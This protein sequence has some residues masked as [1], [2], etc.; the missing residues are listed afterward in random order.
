MAVPAIATHGLTKSFGGV[1]VLRG[2]EFTLAAGEALALFGPNGAGKSTLLRL[3]AALLRPT[4][5]SVKIFGIDGGDGKP[6]VRRR[7]GFLSHQ[8]FLYPD[9][10]PIEN[11]SFY[12]RMFRVADVEKR[13]RDLIEQVG[14]IGWANR[15]VRTLSRGLEQRCALARALLHDPDLLLLD[16]PFTGLDVDASAT[17]RAVLDA[18]HQRGTA[19]VM[20]THDVA[21]GL[22]SCGRA[23]ILARGHLVWDG[24]V[25]ATRRDEF[26]R[27]LLATIHR[28]PR[29]PTAAV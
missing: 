1:P 8:S 18:A 23:V 13:V 7:I 15:P 5:G 4:G 27:T 28:A 22:A 17:L 12:A 25:S 24:P 10:T 19:L 6:D 2:L 21:Q 9:L 14:L 16:E 20:T 11:L 26:E 29:P 3:C